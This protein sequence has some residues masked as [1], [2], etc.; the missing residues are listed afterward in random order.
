MN[1][2]LSLLSLCSVS[3][4]P[5]F[6][7]PNQIKSP[8]FNLYH[9]KFSR[10]FNTAFYSGSKLN[11]KIESCIFNNILNS[12]IKIEKEDLEYNNQYFTETLEFHMGLLA[13]SHCTFKACRSSNIGGALLTSDIS[14]LLYC[15]NFIGNSAEIC[16]AAR[17]LRCASV[18]WFGNTF[19][20]NEADYDG[21]FSMD[22][23]D[24]I[25]NINLS[26]TNISHN[27]AKLWTGGFRIDS[28]GGSI[29]NCVVDGNKAKVAGGFFDFSWSPAFR[30]VKF[31]FFN[32][33]TSKERAAAV[34]AFHLMHNSKY[35]K[36]AFV[37]N[38]CDAKPDSITIDSIDSKIILDGCYFDGPKDTQIGMRFGY[39]TF[40]ILDKTIFD[41]KGSSKKKYVKQI[42]QE[43]DK[44]R[45]F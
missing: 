25:K 39:S 12:A 7:V 38:K 10:F 37:L 14:I 33:N 22:A 11:S 27:T 8:Y 30:D 17:M 4:S 16:G 23:Y 19:Y 15:T 32:N 45:K 18:Q 41:Q 9:S 29:D 21:A 44:V 1:L 3:Y 43:I 2:T 28:V 36:V 24:K 31:C 26:A 6:V 42:Q 34:C 20:K 5:F 13:L 40:E 35:Y